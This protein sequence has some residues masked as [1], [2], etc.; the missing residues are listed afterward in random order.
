MLTEILGFFA[1]PAV[2]SLVGG[3]LGYFNRKNDIALKK[4]EVD[5]ERDRWVHQRGLREL[6]M[7][8]V[9]VENEGRRDVAVIEADALVEK[10]IA[11]A[12]ARAQASD[13]VNAAELKA[14]GGFGRFLLTLVMVLQKVIRPAATILLLASATWLNAEFIGLLRGE[15]WALLSPVERLSLGRQALEWTLT[16]ASLVLSYWFVAR[17]TGK[18]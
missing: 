11:E 7:Q 12:R 5:L 18:S 15:T 8:Q 6:D 16:Q 10:A 13:Q 3:V 9:R 14:A 1:G 4:I 2:G 17:G